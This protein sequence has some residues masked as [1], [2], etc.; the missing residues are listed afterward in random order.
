M[1]A[2]LL[3]FTV[4]LIIIRILQES[5]YPKKR[6]TTTTTYCMRARRDHREGVIGFAASTLARS[7]GSEGNSAHVALLAFFHDH[8]CRTILAPNVWAA[9]GSTRTPLRL[10]KSTTTCDGGSVAVW[11]RPDFSSS[12]TISSHVLT[13]LPFLADCMSVTTR[14]CN[15]L[16]TLMFATSAKRTLAVEPRLADGC[17]NP[18]H[19]QRKRGAEDGCDKAKTGTDLD[20]DTNT[21]TSNQ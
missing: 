12:P 21:N 3:S 13:C 8:P 2:V 6:K 16:G 10:L 1:S 20:F 14:S 5:P 17:K 15:C 7:A 11:A 4:K 19:L 9:F 18:E